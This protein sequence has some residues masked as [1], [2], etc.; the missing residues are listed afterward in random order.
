[1]T[2]CLV[3]CGNDEDKTYYENSEF[4]YQLS[5]EDQLKYAPSPLFRVIYQNEVSGFEQA[6]EAN[7]EFFT[8]KNFENDTPLA[9][10]I[11]LRRS[12]MIPPLI[13]RM[14]LEELKTPN[15]NGR[16]F[17]S[18]LAEIDDFRSFEIIQRRYQQRVNVFVN[19]RPG[20]YFSNFDFPDDYK[21]NA[22][23]YV[24]SKIFMDLLWSTWFHRTADSLT[25]WSKLFWQEDM[26]E[27][28]FL[29]HAAKYNKFDI[30][31]WYTDR[32]CGYDWWNKSETFGFKYV[33]T[34][35]DHILYGLDNLILLLRD[36]KYGPIWRSLINQKNINGNTPMHLAASNGSF[37]SVRALFSCEEMSPVV[38]NN[39]DQTPMT[40]MLSQLD[41]FENPISGDFKNSFNLLLG[42]IDPLNFIPRYNFKYFVNY[43]DLEGKNAAHYASRLADKYFFNELSKYDLGILNM[44]GNR[45]SD[46]N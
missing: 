13:E 33:K 8:R 1:M 2:L 27:N 22:S 11:K 14:T 24:Q 30:I 10:A 26:D 44:E 36:S 3:H 38:L 18:L 21:R 43:Q 4:F 5:T 37:E 46:N 23:H 7:K 41:V 16:S 35:L 28:N 17:V 42:Q 45:A 19:L 20:Q 9:V 31:Q 12:E 34:G 25:I 29:H 6:L 32:S 39:N 15:A 40:Y